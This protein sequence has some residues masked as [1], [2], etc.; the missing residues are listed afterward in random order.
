[1]NVLGSINIADKKALYVVP[2]YNNNVSLSIRN[3]PSV[4][5][6][7]LSDINTYD[8]VNSEVIVLSESAAKIFAGEEAEVAA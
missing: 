3:V 7:L 4:L 6:V 1:M 2:E 8:I 5:G